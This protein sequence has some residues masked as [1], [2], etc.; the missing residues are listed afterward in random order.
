[1]CKPG[2][3]PLGSGS[4]VCTAFT[5]KT[6]CVKFDIGAATTETLYLNSYCVQCPSEF[7]Y[8]LNGRCYACPFP[9][10]TCHSTR[11]IDID[12]GNA[13]GFCTS[14]FEGSGDLVLYTNKMFGICK[15]CDSSCKTC[16]GIYMNTAPDAM[17]RKCESCTYP[18][19][20][21]YEL[22]TE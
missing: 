20:F 15:T 21:A 3:F 13:N 14:C 11:Y 1:M 2:F 19:Y 6:D 22:M 9:C 12:D 8:K 5:K 10:R 7:F 18:A 17:T 16:S 4:G